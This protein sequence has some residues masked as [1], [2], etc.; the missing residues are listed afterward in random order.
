MSVHYPKRRFPYS[1]TCSLMALGDFLSHWTMQKG[2]QKKQ[3][4]EFC[5][6]FVS[7]LVRNH[8]SGTSGCSGSLQLWLP[9]PPVWGHQ[10]FWG[11]LGMDPAPELI[12]PWDL[13]I[14]LCS[15]RRICGP[16]T[17]KPAGLT[18]GFLTPENTPD[19]L[20]PLLSQHPTSSHRT[21]RGI[22][23]AAPPF[24]ANPSVPRRLPALPGGCSRWERLR[25]HSTFS[26]LQLTS[27]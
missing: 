19:L 26:L 4:L 17:P 9:S 15:T 18:G 7:S 6:G 25:G 27:H 3:V 20:P 13:G 22:L 5:S 14:P 23:G 1:L 11:D 24:W 21:E 16:T 2:L 10:H 8:H 12:T